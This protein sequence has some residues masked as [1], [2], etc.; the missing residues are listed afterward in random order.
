VV[1]GCRG[2]DCGD[3]GVAEAGEIAH[4]HQIQRP[5]APHRPSVAGGRS[6][7]AMT[8]SRHQWRSQAPGYKGLGLGRRG[9]IICSL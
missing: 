7:T 3:G 9:K 1:A 2:G 8:R 6:S 4:G 5:A